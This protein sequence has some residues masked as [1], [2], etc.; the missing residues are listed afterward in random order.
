MEPILFS[1]LHGQENQQLKKAL[2]QSMQQLNRFAETE[3]ANERLRHLL[4]FEKEVP[5]AHDCR[6]GGGQGPVCLVK[7]RYCGQ[8]KP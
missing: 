5:T 1:G 7:D 4:G 3:L 8:R 6:Q 2:G